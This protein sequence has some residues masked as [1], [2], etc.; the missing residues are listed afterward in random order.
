[1]AENDNADESPLFIHGDGFRVYN[2][3]DDDFHEFPDPELNLYTSEEIQG[4]RDAIQE[5]II[6]QKKLRDAANFCDNIDRQGDDIQIFDDGNHID[7]STAENQTMMSRSLPLE[8][9]D[10]CDDDNAL[11]QAIAEQGLP[12]GVSAVEQ[13]EV[14]MRLLTQQLRRGDWAN[15][16]TL[17]PAL[18][19]RLRDFQ[20]AQRKRRETYGNERPYGILGLYDHL[21]GIRLDVEW[22]EDA[23]WRRANKEPYLSWADFNQKHSKGWNEPWFTYLLILICTGMLVASFGLNDWLMEPI[24]INPMIGPSAN[25]LI[26][27]GA[28]QTALIVNQGE[29]YRLFSPMFLHAGVI[30]YFLNMVALWLIGRAVEQCHGFMAA[31]ILFIIPAV[32]GTILSALFLPEYISVGASGGIFGLIGACIADICM[33]WSLLFSKHAFDSGDGTR[34]R[35]VKVLLWLVFDI[36]INCL[37]GLTPFVDNFTHLGGMVY[38]FLCGLS[39]IE[40]LSTDFFGIAKSKC[41]IVRN[42]IVRFAGLLLSVVLIMITTAVLVD[43]SGTGSPCINC[44]YISCVPFPPWA[45][46]DNKWWYCDDCAR[47]TADAKLDSKGYYSLAMSCPDGVIKNVDLSDT[48]VTDRQW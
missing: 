40:R 36:V 22:A 46:E 41:E 38:G 25:T 28:K 18:E 30:H 44:R 23:S 26:K 29:W 17:S 5:R 45:N 39:T 21:A 32:G 35:H 2:P 1:M 31:V 9:L 14:M 34:I 11:A 24:N 33:N 37:V 42:G 48:A 6:F 27:L 10:N 12:P 47:V 19:Q 7:K 13:Q 4:R 8:K 20:F 16:E 43:S 15:D 3:V